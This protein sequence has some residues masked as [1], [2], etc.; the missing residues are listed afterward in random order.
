MNRLSFTHKINLP[1]IKTFYN[2]L[3]YPE[4]P[5][6]M[7]DV[8]ITTVIGDRL[9][10]LAQQFYKDV[11]LWWIIAAANM[12]V[13]RRDSFGLESGLEIRIPYDFNKIMFDFEELNDKKIY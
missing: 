8:Y 4:I 6:S 12:N 2:R 7:N 9:D 13:V 1:N 3:K 5:L 11:D 10:L